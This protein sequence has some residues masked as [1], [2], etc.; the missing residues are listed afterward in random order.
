MR[1]N[2]GP[3]ARVEGRKFDV[4]A[5]AASAASSASTSG[6]SCSS[7]SVA[8]Q[9]HKFISIYNAHYPLMQSL[10]KVILGDVK[11]KQNIRKEVVEWSELK[12]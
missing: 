1:S 4:P 6:L 11:D 5:A 7:W 3:G 9:T 12:R 8:G 10:L 2:H